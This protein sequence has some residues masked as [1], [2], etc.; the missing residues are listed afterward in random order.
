M[1]LVLIDW[2]KFNFSKLPMDL[3]VCIFQCSVHMTLNL[4]WLVLVTLQAAQCNWVPAEYKYILVP[5]HV[6]CHNSESDIYLWFDHFD[7][8]LKRSTKENT[9]VRTFPWVFSEHVDAHMFWTLLMY[10]QVYVSGRSRGRRV[11]RECESEI[12]TY[13]Y[14]LLF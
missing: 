9:P 7:F 14:L 8:V 12:F 10:L 1:K 2:N 5:K 3:V 11:G 6:V 4:L 13:L